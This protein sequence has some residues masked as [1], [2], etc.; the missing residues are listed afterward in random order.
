MG[1]LADVPVKRVEMRQIRSRRY[2]VA[3]AVLVTAAAATTMYAFGHR[4]MSQPTAPAPVQQA[5][6]D[7]VAATADTVRPI[8]KLL[9]IGDSMTGWMAER[10]NQYGAE[11]GFEVATIVWD[12]ST[13]KKWAASPR[14]KKYVDDIDPDAVIVSLGMNEMFETNPESRLGAK[15][16]TLLA[17]LGRRP[18]VW[19]GPPSWPGHNEGKVLD[20]WLS[21][22][23]GE[24][25]YFRSFGLQLPRQSK[26]NPH[27]SRAGIEQWVDSL[28][29][30]LP[31]NSV[32]PLPEMQAPAKGKISRGKTFIYRRMKEGL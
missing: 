3:T 15:T 4:A 14:L 12:G 17:S 26:S 5:A 7:S 25:R 16:D 10:L 19:V 23:L 18:Y 24:G 13:I 28:A 29:A 9:I 8:G 32:I 20:E 2:I 27:P 11:N 30:W 21:A 1:H 31:G 6:T 22:R